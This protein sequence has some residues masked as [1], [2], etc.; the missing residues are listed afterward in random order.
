VKQGREPAFVTFQYEG[1]EYY[2]PI[3]N[4]AV[5]YKGKKKVIEATPKYTYN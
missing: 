5:I 1:S 3:S 2:I 4:I